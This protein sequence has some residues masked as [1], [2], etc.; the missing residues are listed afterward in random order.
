MSMKIELMEKNS[1]DQQLE[2][3]ITLKQLTQVK[4]QA[5]EAMD[6]SICVSDR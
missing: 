1:S 5:F 6:S 2:A 3:R 4:F